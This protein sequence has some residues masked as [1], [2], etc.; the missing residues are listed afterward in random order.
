MAI[1]QA[2]NIKP[3]EVEGMP[4]VWYY[5]IRKWIEAQNEANKPKAK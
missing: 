2:A 3:W 5:R 4:A 1:A